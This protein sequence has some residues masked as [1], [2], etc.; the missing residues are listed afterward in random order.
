[1]AQAFAKGAQDFWFQVGVV[2]SYVMAWPGQRDVVGIRMQQDN[3]V[4]PKNKIAEFCRR[5]HIRWLAL[6]GS[7]LREDF[8]PDSDIDVLVEFEPGHIPGLALIRMQ[9]ELSALLGGHEVD[10]VT[11]KFLHPRIRERVL[12]EM[13]VQYAQG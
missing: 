2:V 13:E 4:I 11:P 7:V 9:D 1:L 5:N 10:L 3:L 12:T 8:S 6:F